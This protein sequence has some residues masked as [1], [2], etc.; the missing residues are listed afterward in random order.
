[1]TEPVRIDP[2]AA[3]DSAASLGEGTS[4]GAFAVI[5]PKVVLGRRVKIGPS[6]VIEG[7]TEIGDEC[8]VHPFSSLGG[9]PQD[10]K[11]RGEETR[12]VIGVRN[13]F[14]ESC[15]IN[16]G[17]AGGGGLTTIG[18]GNLFM[19]ASHVAHDCRVGSGTIFANAATLAGH[20]TVGSHSTIGAYS[21]V[22]QYC[23]IGEYAFIGG[24]SVVT[25]DALPY[26]LTVGNRAES[27]GINVIGL[28]RRGFSEEAIASLRR[29]Y[30]RLFRSKLALKEA[31]D[32]VEAEMGTIPEVA[33]LLSFIRGS[34]RGVIR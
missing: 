21:G 4:V 31:L 12:L 7:P 15:T 33:Y 22:H 32:S 1:M 16:R 30:R 27:H 2:R 23:R 6:V 9:P 25:Q 34:E 14:R 11:Y 28:K 29:A 26:T 3:V 8:A 24:Y 17:T 5:G 19:A 20:V 10:L 13:I 18:D